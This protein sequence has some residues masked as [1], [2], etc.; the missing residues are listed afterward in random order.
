MES[1]VEEIISKEHAREAKINTPDGR[2]WYLPH[3]SV[4]HPHKL[5]KLRVVFVCSAELNGISINKEL[6]PGPDLANK[7][8]GVLTKF[9]VNKATFVADIKKC[10]FK[11]LLLRSIKSASIFMVERRKHLRQAN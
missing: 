9:R 10:I 11:Y 5:N 8:V 7:L 4:Y 3:H 2:T 6:L 1:T